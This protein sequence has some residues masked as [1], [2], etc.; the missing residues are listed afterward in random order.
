M[1]RK[2]R[3]LGLSLLLLLLL[4]NAC[5]VAL[6][7][8]YRPKD[9]F[10]GN[11]PRSWFAADS[12]HFLFNTSIDLM[13]N[14]FSGIMVIKPVA[15]GYY[16]VVF[17]T[18]VGLKI[19]DME[20]SPDRQT[21]VHYMMDAMNKKGLVNTLSNDISLV[22]MN[23]LSDVQPDILEKRDSEDVI[24]RYREQK[25]RSYYFLSGAHDKPYMAKQTGSISNKARADLFGSNH[26]GIDS[27][28]ITHYNL[29][30]SINLY[31][32]NEESNHVAE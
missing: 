9:D 10:S 12:G 6:F 19:F 15:D 23:G 24:F 8:G 17:I 7:N 27:V 30:L 2:C 1:K 22:L 32:I 16:R 21:K 25:T 4:F 18:E 3:H 29:G 28:K 14:H 11:L 5:S 26:T 20:F 13:K 31:R